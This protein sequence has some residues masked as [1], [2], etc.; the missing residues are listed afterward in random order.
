M[1]CIPY[2]STFKHIHCHCKQRD[3]KRRRREP[4]T[5]APQPHSRDEMMA[6]SSAKWRGPLFSVVLLAHMANAHTL[7]VPKIRK[8]TIYKLPRWTLC[9]TFAFYV[10]LASEGVR[11]QSASSR[12]LLTK[13]PIHKCAGLPASTHTKE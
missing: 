10:F 13:H 11:A 8:I 5:T 12:I 1:P 2:M 3:V 4:G 7:L 9:P 6:P